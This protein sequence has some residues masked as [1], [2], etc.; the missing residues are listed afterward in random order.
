MF[1]PSARP[2][3]KP[4]TTPS[5]A[6]SLCFE[7]QLVVFE[8]FEDQNDPVAPHWSISRIESDDNLT[9]FLGRFRDGELSEKNYPGMPQ[10]AHHLV[11]EFD[12]Y[13]ID[14]W[15]GRRGGDTLLAFI[16]GDEIDFG[17]FGS[18]VFEGDRTGITGCGS[19]WVMTSQGP[20]KEIGF[21][22]DGERFFDQI[23]HATIVVPNRCFTDTFF[24]ILRIG[25]QVNTNTGVIDFGSGGFDNLRIAAEYPCGTAPTL[26]PSTM[27]PRRSL[28]P[29][30]GGVG[31]SME[32][33]V[34]ITD[35][36]TGMPSV[37]DAQPT[38]LPLNAE[39]TSPISSERP[40]APRRT[41]PPVVNAL[42]TTVSNSPPSTAEST[43]QH[44]N[45]ATNPLLINIPPTTAPTTKPLGTYHYDVLTPTSKPL[46]P[47]DNM[48]R[49]AGTNSYVMPPTQPSRRDTGRTSP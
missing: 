15:N 1:I 4:T 11:V 44:G 43:I 5:A 23:H 6:P 3:L 2:S 9:Q 29:T 35:R 31:P 14:D 10:Q 48:D 19:S 20:P 33:T 39:P 21:A 41:L 16:N 13:E 7:E 28:I 37:L 32:P 46:M 42:V 12:F 36:R 24:G 38:E 49:V 47:L 18:D 17:M 40:T 22:S 30:V 34:P 26:S 45:Y 25:F 27:D 8:D